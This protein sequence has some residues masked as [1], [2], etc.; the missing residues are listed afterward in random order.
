LI[1]CDSGLKHD[2]GALHDVQKTTFGATDKAH[3]VESMVA[4]CRQ[5][6][7]HLIRG[8]LLDFGRSL[9]KAWQIKRELS[10]SISND[11]LDNV[12][13]SAIGAGALGGKLMGAG[14]GGFFMFFVQAQHRQRV[15][16]C[17]REQG[18]RLS[19]FRFETG[20]V[21]SWRTKVH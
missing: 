4:L 19:N 2:S 18:C 9:A 11:K 6:H 14:G 20:G 21:T 16:Q 3:E 1:L 12:Y 8:E 7:K 17:L 5:M 13:D 10:S 15:A